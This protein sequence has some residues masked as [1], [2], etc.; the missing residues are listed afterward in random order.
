MVSELAVIPRDLSDFGGPNHVNH[1][2]RLYNSFFITLG[3]LSLLYEYF[4]NWFIEYSVARV[5]FV[6]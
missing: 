6:V 5:V 4:L 1:T 3:V 2:T